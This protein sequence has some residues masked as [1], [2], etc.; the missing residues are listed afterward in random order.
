MDEL[1]QCIIVSGWPRHSVSSA[2]DGELKF[3]LPA[4][5]CFLPLEEADGRHDAT[6]K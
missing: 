1:A 3:W 4:L 6:A 2:L 5:L